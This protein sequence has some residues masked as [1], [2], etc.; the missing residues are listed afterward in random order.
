MWGDTLENMD[1]AAEYLQAI[2][3]KNASILL[4]SGGFGRSLGSARR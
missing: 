4:F 2:Q 3:D 1:T